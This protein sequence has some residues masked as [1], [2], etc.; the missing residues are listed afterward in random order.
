M[1]DVRRVVTGHSP[2]GK[3]VFVSD[4]KVTA[5]PM[6]QDSAGGF[7]QLWG[8]DEAPTFPDDGTLPAQAT[9]FPPVGGYRFV[10]VTMPPAGPRRPPE[11]DP[12]ANR[13]AMERRFPGLAAHMEQ[14]NPGMHTTDTIDFEYVLSGEIALELDDGAEVVL[15]PG[16]TVVQNGT[17]HRWH[18]RTSEPAVYVAFL[19]G[20]HRK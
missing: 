16:D 3:A 1:Q 11:G 4:E 19:L 2:E 8:G 14:D 18:N 5:A 12:E 6:G 20:A 15:H 7:N 10:V 17:R 9:F 13:S